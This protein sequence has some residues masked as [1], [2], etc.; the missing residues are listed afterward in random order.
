MK[1]RVSIINK[2]LSKNEN[3]SLN[4]RI[5]EI[6]KQYSDVKL[7]KDDYLSLSSQRKD[8]NKNKL[9]DL[10]DFVPNY[11]ITYLNIIMEKKEKDS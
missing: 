8:I 10:I 1:C 11:L 5:S 3:Y 4:R 6:F 7:S 2:S 9:H